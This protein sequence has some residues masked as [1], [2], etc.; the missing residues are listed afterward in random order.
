MKIRGFVYTL[1]AFSML[2]VACVDKGG[3][4]AEQ[5]NDNPIEQPNEVPDV[6]I[7]AQEF[8]GEYYGDINSPGAGCYVLILSDNELGQGG[9][10]V[11]NSVYYVLDVYSDI[12]DGK[13]TGYVMLPEGCYTLDK[14]NTMAKGTIGSEYSYYVVTGELVV[15]KQVAFDSAE[16]VVTPS[17]TTLT[18]V[19]EG[20]KHIVTFDGQATIEDKR[21]MDEKVTAAYAWAYYYSD[22][23]SP[24]QSDNFLLYLS[25]IDND[26][27]QIPDASYYRLD[28]Y[29]E[30]IDIEEGLALPYGTYTI[31]VENTH[32]PNTI[33]V[34][35]SMF[36]RV[37]ESGTGYSDNAPITGGTV[38]VDKSGVT[39]ELTIMGATHKVTFKGNVFVQ[40]FSHSGF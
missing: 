12:F 18:A 1:L 9:G 24:G 3:D 31:D 13:D 23:Y 2:F 14:E 19:V 32:N 33:A 37:N 30:I 7:D 25:D 29:S 8:V 5:P 34:A 40:D 22:N 17:S 27:N 26:F 28:L 39:A 10:M 15:E 38:V 20:V 35:D 11:A 4:P 36:L 6:V 21:V 16:L